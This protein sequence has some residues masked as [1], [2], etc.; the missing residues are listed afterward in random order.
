VQVPAEAHATPFSW[1]SM[2]PAGFGVV[3]TVQAI[4]FH[5]SASVTWVPELS[6]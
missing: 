1:L 5:D 2:A 3:L 4:P 6:L